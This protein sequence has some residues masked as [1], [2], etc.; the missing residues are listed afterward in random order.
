MFKGFIVPA[1]GNLGEKSWHRE[2]RKG[3]LSR[4]FKYE[5]YF[6]NGIIYRVEKV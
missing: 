2:L 4:I 5:I 3:K 1:L 6:L